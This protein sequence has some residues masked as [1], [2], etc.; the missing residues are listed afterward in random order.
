MHPAPLY[1]GYLETL[2]TYHS[3]STSHF[4]HS[5]MGVLLGA[6][7]VRFACQPACADVCGFAICISF[8]LPHAI[9]LVELA[10]PSRAEITHMERL[11]KTGI[12]RSHLLY[13]HPGLAIPQSGISAG[14]NGKSTAQSHAACCWLVRDRFLA[15]ISFPRTM[16]RDCLDSD[17]GG[18]L[19]SSPRG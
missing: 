15:R 12:T 10:K 6:Y 14:C 17:W 18:S 13:V 4:C 5:V 2:S 8:P 3:C 19:F 16:G 11:G 7:Q 9:Y 1:C